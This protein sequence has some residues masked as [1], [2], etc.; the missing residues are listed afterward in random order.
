MLPHLS[1]IFLALALLGCSSTVAPPTPAGGSAAVSPTPA[2]GSD[3]QHQQPAGH[4]I[5]TFSAADGLETCTLAKSP[6]ESHLQCG[7]AAPF[8]IQPDASRVIQLVEST[9]WRD[10]LDRPEPEETGT[11]R[12]RVVRM[13]SNGDSIELHRDAA[14]STR[15]GELAAALDALEAEARARS[16]G[17]PQPPPPMFPEV[18]DV[19]LVTMQIQA[20]TGA[21]PITIRIGAD[22]AWSRTGTAA[23]SGTLEARQLA[24]VRG[25][26]DEVSRAKANDRRGGM[27]CD[28]L[29]IY[30]IRVLLAGGRELGWSGPCAGPPPPPAAVILA[31]FMRQLADGR[32][33]S[34]LEAT[35]ARPR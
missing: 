24:A 1:P 21:D 16:A 3:T 7:T 2:G 28:A 31:M 8:A 25:L 27:P 15:F 14:P 26:I 22:G 20:L 4:W 11:R 34:E 30:M 5:L 35:L 18:S 6:S 9:S 19:G 33:A 12:R 17:T 29:P 13:T 32:P 10:E 23:S